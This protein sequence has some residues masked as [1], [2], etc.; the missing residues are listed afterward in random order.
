[1]SYERKREIAIRTVGKEVTQ[2]YIEREMMAV[3]VDATYGRRIQNA[4]RRIVEPTRA[5]SPLPQTLREDAYPGLGADEI[6]IVREVIAEVD[7]Y[8]RFEIP[9][10][11]PAAAALG[12]LG[13]RAFAQLTVHTGALGET[14]SYSYTFL[15]ERQRLAEAQVR[16]GMVVRCRLRGVAVPEREPVWLC[17]HIEFAV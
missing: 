2:Q 17:D 13:T 16:K 9:R 15:I 4:Y 10:T 14:D 6:G 1:M 8:D 3:S 11:S 5:P 12:E 7:I